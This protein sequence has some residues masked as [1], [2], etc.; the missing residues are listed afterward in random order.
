MYE[1]YV[2]CIYDSLVMQIIHVFNDAR[3]TLNDT[4]IKHGLHC[5]LTNKLIAL[6]IPFKK[7]TPLICTFCVLLNIPN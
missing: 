1:V 2:Q 6:G 3:K 7:P 5:T 4:I